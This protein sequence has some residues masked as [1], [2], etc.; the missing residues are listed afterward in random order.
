MPWKFIHRRSSKPFP[1]TQRFP[2]GEGRDF[3]LPIK[4]PRVLPDLWTLS[5]A[6][7]VLVVGLGGQRARG[8]PLKPPWQLRIH[9]VGPWYVGDVLSWE[10]RPL[11]RGIP[12]GARVKIQVDPPDGPQWEATVAPWGIDQVPAAVVPWAWETD[13]VA[14]G[15][16]MVTVR[17]Q[18]REVLRER[19]Y[20]FPSD[21]RP[22]WERGV[23]WAEW[24]TPCCQVVYFTQTETEQDLP[25][26]L[27]IVEETYARV[28]QQMGIQPHQ[29]AIIVFLPRLLGQGGFLANEMWVSYRDR[30]PLM[31][32]VGQIVHHEMVHWVERQGVK[33]WRPT[34]LVEGLAVFLSGG[35]YRPGEPLFRRAHALLQ[36]GQYKPLSA[37][38]ENFYQHQHELA[39]IQAGALVAYMVERWG[40][41]RF[42]AF[43]TSLEAP[44]EGE[45]DM[46]ALSRQLERGFGLTLEAL[47]RD[48]QAFLRQHPATPEDLE[49]VQTTVALYEALRAYQKAMDPDAYY[50]TAWLPQ[51]KLMQPRGIVT[52]ALRSPGTALHLTAE[53][54]LQQASLAWLAGDYPQARR[55]IE[56]VHRLVGAYRRGEVI[57]W[58]H[59]PNARSIRWW[60][61]WTWG[62]GGELQRLDLNTYPP[63]A[64]VRSRWRSPDLETWILPAPGQPRE[65]PSSRKEVTR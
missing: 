17:Y 10:V 64:Q 65:C 20:L 26:L 38:G 42:W 3:D 19:L 7:L 52:D 61:A 11:E 59:L 21:L 27:Q 30:G 43:Y 49:D 33:N 41:E 12:R 46:Q 31:E 2:W 9:P 36:W 50:G 57:S 25:E 15:V 63:R 48:F 16:H 60:V 32:P 47:D 23:Q 35:H 39:Y 1:Q 53:L 44:R 8:I 29:R 56:E 40:W 14:P 51:R 22:F 62:C 34:M 4:L 58:E 5:L 24:I 45:T 54:L 13:F 55:Y 28:T 37:L 18:G 6:L